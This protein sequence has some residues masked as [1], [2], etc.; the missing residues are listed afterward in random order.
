MAVMGRPLGGAQLVCNGGKC[1][2][3]E[4]TTSSKLSLNGASQGTPV[5]RPPASSHD[6]GPPSAGLQAQSGRKTGSERF[7]HRA[8]R[9]RVGVA[10]EFDLPDVRLCQ[11]EA[12]ILGD[13]G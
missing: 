1:L 4:F 5:F 8:L 2:S 7:H 13:R 6:R 10:D 11:A 9:H 12:L 3:I